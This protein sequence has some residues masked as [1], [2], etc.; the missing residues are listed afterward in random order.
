MNGDT[1]WVKWVLSLFAIMYA[2]AIGHLHIRINREDEKLGKL[3][4][5]GKDRRDRIWATVTQNSR[6]F[7]DFKNI[8]YKDY[9]TK[10]DLKDTEKRII[11]AVKDNGH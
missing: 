10:E 8:V 4:S 6:E 5:E 11:K 3:G 2:A 7:N 9:P 1:V